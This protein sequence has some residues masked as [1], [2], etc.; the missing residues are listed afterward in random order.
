MEDS[1][2]PAQPS[3]APVAPPPDV[4]M[5]PVENAPEQTTTVAD[6]AAQ[7]PNVVPRV[8]QPPVQPATGPAPETGPYR[9][10]KVEDALAYLDK[11][12]CF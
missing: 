10:L 4:E 7:Q 3:V 1:A 9:Q 12:R 5:T 11:V 2:Q 6:Q 8:V